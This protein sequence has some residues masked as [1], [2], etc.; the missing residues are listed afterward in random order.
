MGLA[1]ALIVR[2]A[3]VAFAACAYDN[4]ATCFERENLYLLSEMDL[5]MHQAVERQVA[6][7]GPIDV[8]TTS[9]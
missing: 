7:P 3:G 5:E 4:A 1:G 6:G 2:P 8:A 9:L